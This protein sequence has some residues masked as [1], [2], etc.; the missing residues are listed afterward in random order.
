MA[1]DPR[2]YYLF[3][4]FP[5]LFAGGGVLWERLL[6]KPRLRWVKPAY[7]ALMVLMAALLAPTLIPLLSPE[8]YIRYAAATHLQQPRLENH[9]LGLLPQLFADQFGWPEMAATVAGAYKQ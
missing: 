5:I 3:S 1:L 2:V 7:G 8:T 6:A 9:E 4:V